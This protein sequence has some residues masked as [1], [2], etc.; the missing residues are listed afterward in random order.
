ML[1][2]NIYGLGKEYYSVFYPANGFNEDKF[3]EDH[4]DD[5]MHLDDE[6]IDMEM[7]RWDQR[8]LGM[9]V[10]LDGANIETSEDFI[11]N[12]SVVQGNNLTLRQKVEA[13]DDDVAIYWMHSGIVEYEF[14]WN[15]IADFNKSKLKLHFFEDDVFNYMT[16]DGEEADESSVINFEPKYGYGDLTILY[17]NGEQKEID[18]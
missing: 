17:P 9:D 1:T 12:S 15:D 2:I 7:S 14:T 11:K 18:A 4:S 8:S 10:V 3:V 16:Y 13:K 6:N 5:Y